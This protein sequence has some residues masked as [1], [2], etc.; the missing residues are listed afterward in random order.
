VRFAFT[1]DQLAFRDATRDLLEKQCG[2]EAVRTAWD[3]RS[4]G[5]DPALWRRLAEMGVLGALA[6]EAAG[7]LGLSEL[8]LV[9][10]L[11]ESG[12]AAM[13]GPMVEHAAVAVPLLASS[14]QGEQWLEG[15]VAGDLLVTVGLGGADAAVPWAAQADVVL[16]ADGDSVS[17]AL[18]GPAGD[19][20]VS[21]DRSRRAA[22]L[23][24]APV[25]TTLLD[26]ADVGLAFDR[27]ALATAA[28]LLGLSEKLIEMTAEYTR[29]RHQFGVPIGSYQAVKHQLA[30]ALIWVEYARPCIYRASH[31][32]ARQEPNRSR[33]VSLAKAYANEAASLSA[34]VALQC[35]GAI[36]YTYE[37]DLHLWMKRV[38]ALRVAWGDTAFHRS[39]VAG[40]VLGPS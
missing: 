15:A 17:A 36:G 27:G 25:A 1:E 9:L 38:W 14:P 18:A 6:P 10:V 23:G 5:Y 22:L 31:S 20:R 35:H 19:P 16:R 4:P 12:R 7:G 34:R 3:A 26:G 13:P 29:A 2:P 21:V 33:D 30:N 28:Q 8:D 11:E 24:R 37:Y 32:V 40:A 39:R